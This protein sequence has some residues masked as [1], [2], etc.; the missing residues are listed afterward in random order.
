MK[1]KKMGKKTPKVNYF[2]PRMPSSIWFNEYFFMCSHKC[3]SLFWTYDSAA[4]AI[5][6]PT[7]WVV[8]YANLKKEQ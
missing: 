8:S 6:A 4:D 1:E 3:L 7:R 2:S 5:G